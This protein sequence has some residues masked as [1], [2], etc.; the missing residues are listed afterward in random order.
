M[1]VLVA[2]LSIPDILRDYLA[3]ERLT[4]GQLAVKLRVNPSQVSSWITGKARSSLENARAISRVTGRPLNEV[5]QAAGFPPL[6]A[7]EP[8]PAP[9][10]TWIAETLSQL[11]EFELRVVDATARGLLRVREE[12]ERY[13]DRA[14]DA[15]AAPGQSPP[16]PP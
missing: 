5:L 8:A 13:G 16:P 9:V 11:D 2:Q 12:R 1:V 4:Q 6:A 10:P 15:P 14:P 3:R 7:P